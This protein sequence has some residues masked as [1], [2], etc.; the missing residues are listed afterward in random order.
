MMREQHSPYRTRGRAQ[1]DGD[2]LQ[3][4]SQ[5]SWHGST[6]LWIPLS[7]AGLLLFW[8]MLVFIG[9]YPPFILPAPEL[10]AARWFQEMTGGV[11][12]NHTLY[13]LAE[14]IGGFTVALVLSL[15]LGYAL[16]H[17][18]R[19][20]RIVSAHIVIIQAIPVVA[21]APLILLW[22]GYDLRSKIMIAAVVTFFPMLSSVIVALRSVPRDLLEMGAISG[23]DRWD[24]LRYIELP[25]ALPTLF[26]G[27]KTGLALA[28]TGA[29][30]AE[31]IG[32]RNGLGALI[33]IARG[34]FDTPLLFVSLLTLALLTLGFYL[35]ALGLERRLIT[36]ND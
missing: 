13:T 23:A 8:R 33:N 9:N 6:R 20:E 21:I 28:T 30:V 34:L 24:T 11:L 18:P 16:A 36:W 31:F 32:G 19:L 22:F 26:G 10:V 17:L 14:A 15:V 29:V 2:T 27:I 5:P 25:L 12:L 7:L 4:R 3:P 1:D 35:I